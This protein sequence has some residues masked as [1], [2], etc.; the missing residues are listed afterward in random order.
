M[1]EKGRVVVISIII[2]VFA[3]VT[4]LLFNFLNPHGIDIINGNHEKSAQFLYDREDGAVVSQEIPDVG[5]PAE[6]EKNEQPHENREEVVEETRLLKDVSDPDREI[7]EGTE[8]SRQAAS[9]DVS[10]PVVESTEQT[11]K[12]TDDTPSSADAAEVVIQPISL[13]KAKEYFDRSEGLFV[14]AR[15]EFQYYK[16]HIPGSL[17]L[18]ASRFD[19]QFPDFEMN[20]DKDKLL[21]LY[22]HSITC[23]YSDIV[24]NKLKGY[25]Y[26]NITIFAGGWTEWL[27]AGYPVQGFP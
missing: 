14:D 21:I 12:V 2:T 23:R 27:Q 26:T 25:G 18:S 22:C 10:V 5:L 15:S 17:S 4:G 13:S 9:P 1:Q 11:E 20:I 7:T 8:D 19:A 16:R 24:A 6:V 3:A